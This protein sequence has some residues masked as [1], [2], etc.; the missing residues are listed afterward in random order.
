MYHI[1]WYNSFE[2]AKFCIEQVEEHGKD[3]CK[4]LVGNNCDKRDER[5]VSEKEGQELADFYYI[6]FFE[7][8]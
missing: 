5:Q 4:I 1:I 8:S 7:A 3:L 2:N 6:L